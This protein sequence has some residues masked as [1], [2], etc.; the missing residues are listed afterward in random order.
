[1]E[2]IT[3]APGS[4][5][6]DQSTLDANLRQRFGVI[7]VGIQRQDRRMEFNPEPGTRDSR[8]RQARRARPAGVAASSSKSEASAAA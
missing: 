4:A 1:M 3:I 6:A 5:L 8:R 7:V 2:E